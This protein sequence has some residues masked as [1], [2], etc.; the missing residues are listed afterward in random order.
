MSKH[1]I[2]QSEWLEWGGGITYCKICNAVYGTPEWKKGCEVHVET[3]C[4]S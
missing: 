1:L 3:P 2:E 4:N